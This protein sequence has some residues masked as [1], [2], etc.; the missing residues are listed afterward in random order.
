MERTFA[1]LQGIGMAWV[2]HIEHLPTV[3]KHEPKPIGY[4]PRGKLRVDALN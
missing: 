1:W 3:L 2:L 4:H